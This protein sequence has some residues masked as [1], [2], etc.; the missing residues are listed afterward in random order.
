M[1]TFMQVFPD[2][3]G[4]ATKFYKNLFAIAPEL[5]P[6]FQKFYL[7]QQ[8]S[9]LMQTLSI[10]LGSV[11][12][13]DVIA[14]EIE[15]LGDRH[16]GFGVEERH[17]AIVG[18]ALISTLSDVLGSDFTPRHETA[19]IKTYALLAGIATRVYDKE[20]FP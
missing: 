10:L 5:K 11:N 14:P 16:R 7:E 4:F 2:A 19:W 1:R 6:L 12:R 3:E 17:Y 15:A 13:L 9:K 18:Q 8:G 20:Y